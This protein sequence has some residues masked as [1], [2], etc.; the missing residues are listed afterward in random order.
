MTRSRVSCVRA[1]RLHGQKN[2]SEELGLLSDEESS[3]ETSLSISAVNDTGEMVCIVREGMMIL[4]CSVG[5]VENEAIFSPLARMM[6][7]D[8]LLQQE[9]LGIMKAAS[10][11][12]TG[13]NGALGSNKC[14]LYDRETLC[15]WHKSY[16]SDKKGL[17]ML[18]RH[19]EI[20]F[21]MGISVV[22]VF[23]ELRRW[24]RRQGSGSIASKRKAPGY[25]EATFR[26]SNEM[27]AQQPHSRLQ[28]S[29]ITV[30]HNH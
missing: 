6:R 1:G 28:P 8:Q 9:Q 27:L 5:V 23:C 16:F 17:C 19:S 2:S 20:H 12:T 26:E 29:T 10:R 30:P 13:A 25:M 21:V 15:G 18:N 24:V 11:S 4:K 22:V 7:A 3:L 14:P